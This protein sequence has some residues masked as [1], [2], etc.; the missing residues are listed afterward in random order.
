MINDD[1]IK[2]MVC[3]YCFGEIAWDSERKYGKCLHCDHQV[4]NERM[5]PQDDHKGESERRYEASVR[6]IMNFIRSGNTEL[7][8]KHVAGL[9]LENPDSIEGWLL[10]RFLFGCEVKGI[11]VD[12]KHQGMERP[13][14]LKEVAEGL[15]CH[16]PRNADILKDYIGDRTVGLIRES[17][18]AI[19]YC[20]DYRSCE[21]GDRFIPVRIRS[22]ELADGWVRANET[23]I[24]LLE[25]AVRNLRE[26]LSR[27]PTPAMTSYCRDTVSEME[28]LIGIHK[29]MIDETK[30]DH[31][32]PLEIRQGFMNR[33]TYTLNGSERSVPDMDGGR[34][35]LGPGVHRFYRRDH[36]LDLTIYLPR[37]PSLRVDIISVLDKRGLIQTLDTFPVNEARFLIIVDH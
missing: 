11:L 32:Y 14:M 1:R 21:S 25:G 3:P 37:A 24:E 17:V 29:R 33:I 6:T 4:I 5:F 35:R 10:F 31:N 27:S 9:V 19:D 12:L 16:D 30:D 28:R 7:A 18:D 22:N 23:K 2:L 26:I 34:C 8:K 36:S 20:R 15:M 13:R